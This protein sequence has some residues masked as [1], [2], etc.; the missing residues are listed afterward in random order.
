M[1]Y[2][3]TNTIDHL[4]YLIPILCIF[5]IIAHHQFNIPLE[6]KFWMRKGDGQFISVSSREGEHT[7]KYV[8]KITNVIFQT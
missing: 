4:P 3:P 8:K 2:L 1:W 5:E 6:N 7:T